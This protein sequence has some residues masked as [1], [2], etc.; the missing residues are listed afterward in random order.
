ME[1]LTRDSYK[2]SAPD[3]RALLWGM[4]QRLMRDDVAYCIDASALL[5][6]WRFYR[7]DEFPEVWECLAELAASKVAIAPAQA[8]EELRREADEGL[9]AWAEANP[10][11]FHELDS[12][13]EKLAA[14]IIAKYQTLYGPDAER[15]DA[16]PYVVALGVT[17]RERNPDKSLEYAVGYPIRW[18]TSTVLTC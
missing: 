7:P 1:P 12:G 8:L 9:W 18:I 10:T 11:L 5:D 6:I 2:D 4:D 15:F 16:S 3:I 17:C 13:Q 14:E